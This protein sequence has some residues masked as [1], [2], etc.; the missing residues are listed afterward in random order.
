VGYDIHTSFE[1]SCILGWVL[2]PFG[3]DSVAGDGHGNDVG[4]V[5][6][7]TAKKGGVFL[8]A[9][10]VAH[11]GKGISVSQLGGGRTGEMQITRFLHNPKVTV[12][13]MVT[14]A[15]A[16]TCTQARGRHVLAIQDTT[17]LRV[18]EK[19][20][21][22]SFHPLIAVDANEGALLGLVDVRFLMRKGGERA[23]RKQRDF[24]EKDSCRWLR[25]AES[26][27]ALVEAGASCVTVIEDREG[28]IYESFAFK[29]A[30][31]EKLVRA[32]QDRRLADGTSLFARAD[33]WTE[34][35][36]MTVD[37]PAAPGRKARQATLSLRYGTVEIKRPKNRKPG[38]R[39]LP[40]TV[41]VT[42]VDA[43]EIDPPEAEQP[44]HWRLLT[45]HQVNDIA[46]ARRI[47]GFY[48]QRWTIEQLFRTMKTKG[49]NVEALRQQQDG[50]LEKLVT[51]VLIAAITVMQL[52]AEREGKAKRPL[53]DAFDPDDRPAL[54]R[55]CQSLEGKTDKQKNPHPKGSLAYA[56]WVF[57]RLGGWT[58]YYGKPGPIIMLRGLT[59][60]HAIK[61]GWD[62][63]NV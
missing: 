48:R 28:D 4:A 32:A 16:R 1:P 61:H 62:L 24:E 19:G 25:G 29:P 10:I 40:E 3:R 35:G 31:I 6:G 38:R 49:F 23:T 52:V 63:R 57:A 51:A 21:G 59:E 50:P 47:I 45:T 60:F 27:S 55:V 26:A 22:L 30:N 41:T 11:G 42:L 9:R 18:D 33:E 39:K 37:L 7:R 8:H 58:G 44:A 56:A 15:S 46:D 36:R 54:E 43:R 5:R 12:S 17:A 13:E 34:A 20:V 53:A 14:T 2:T